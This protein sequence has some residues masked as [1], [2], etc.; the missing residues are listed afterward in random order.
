MIIVPPVSSQ[1]TA[2][3]IELGRKLTAVIQ[4]FKQSHPG[5]SASEIQQALKIA[6]SN[7]G[8]SAQRT[9]IIALLTGLL[10]AGALLAFYFARA[11][12]NGPSSSSMMPY[13]VVFVVI[14]LLVVFK[15]KR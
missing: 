8:A 4:E 7:T 9:Q 6:E 12:D 13:I 11:G 1:A 14:I 10:L 5:V 3:A 15:L 2:T